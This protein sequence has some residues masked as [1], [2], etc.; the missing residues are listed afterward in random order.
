M[1]S[2]P[3]LT[4]KALGEQGLLQK[5]QKFCPQEI[6]GDD[7]AILALESPKHLV[8]TTD[9]L[10]EGV[11]FSDRTTSPEDTGWRATA[12]N[13]SD[14]AAMGASPLGITV[15]LG[16]PAEKRVIW[17]ERLYEGISDCLRTYD[18]LLLGGD[19]CRSPV[20]TVSITALGKIDSSQVIRRD[21]A[22]VGDVLLVTG[23]HGASRGGLELLLNPEKKEILAQ[24]QS[25]KLIKTH[26]RPQP[27][28][29]VISH[30][31][32]L[33]DNASITGMDSSDG[34]ADAV[35]QICQRSQVGA[36][37]E[38]DKIP[39]P[40]ALFSLVSP[41]IALEWALY[42]GEDFELVLALP[43]SLGRSLVQELGSKSAIIGKITAEKTI[44]LVENGREQILTQEE[45][46]Q[47]FS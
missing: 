26:Q 31:H 34:L 41:Q 44:K 25:K 32:G 42:G 17:V 47:H 39:I 23:E 4:V 40:K 28:F 14:L 37:I 13:L 3:N 18:T 19:V 22:T 11:H 45:G 36:I 5:L 6:I 2:D 46:F 27:R 21:T 43:E 38:Q 35:I 29:D 24:K 8:V 12:A 15:A 1:S 20:V 33:N 9:M 7:A 30:L 10:V 16:L